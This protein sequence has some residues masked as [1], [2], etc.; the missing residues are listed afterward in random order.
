MTEIL[1]VIRQYTT[2]PQFETKVEPDLLRPAD[3]PIIYGDSSRLQAATGWKQSYQLK[4]TI[5]DMIE[6]W[7]NHIWHDFQ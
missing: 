6:Y 2:V 1:D 5:H 4:D 3:E 7:R